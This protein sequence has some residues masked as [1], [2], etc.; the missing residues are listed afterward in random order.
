[1]LTLGQW[2]GNKMAGVKE[3]LENLESKYAVPTLSAVNDS[4]TAATSIKSVLHI[5]RNMF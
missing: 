5:L 3:E 2:I 1:M 4:L